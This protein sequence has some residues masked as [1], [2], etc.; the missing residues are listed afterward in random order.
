M[1]TALLVLAAIALSGCGE[2][3]TD[4][5][6]AACKAAIAEKLADKNYD[7]SDSEMRA[8]TSEEQSD[9]VHVAA[10]IVFD[11]GLPREYTQTFD[12]RVR[13]TAGKEQPDV[14]SL[15]FTW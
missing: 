3:D 6:V 12:C 9:L 15:N 2:T 11:A 1:R 8:G 5:A 13:F 4:R 14:I 10:P 7:I